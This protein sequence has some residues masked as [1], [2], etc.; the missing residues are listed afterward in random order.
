MTKRKAGTEY[1]A[2]WYDW[3]S[4]Q[5]CF[6]YWKNGERMQH[7][8][9]TK[10]YFFLR[11]EDAEIVACR[12]FDGLCDEV[13]EAGPYIKLFL[14]YYD[15]RR[16]VFI[17]WLRSKGV[18]PLEADVHPV[19]RYMF[20][21][22]IKISTNPKILY[23][24]I[25]TDARK[26]GWEDVGRHRLL[27]IAYAGRGEKVRCLIVDDSDD[28]GEKDLLNRFF[29]VIEKYDTLVAWNGAAYDEVVLRARAKHYK[30]YPRWNTINFLDL[31]QLFKKY[32]G[33]D[34]SGSGVRISFS[35]ENI[36]KT[37]LGK[38]KVK[39]IAVHRLIDVFNFE[40]D[41]LI[42]YNKRDVEI[43]QELDEKLGYTEAQTALAH[44]CN[45]FLC[46]RSLKSGY[47]VDG[48]VL[49]HAAKSQTA[50]FRTKNYNEGQEEER[51]IEGAFVMDPIIGLHEQVCDL[52]FSS[53]YPSIMIAWNVSPEKK[54]V[55]E[56]DQLEDYAIAANKAKFSNMTSGSFPTIVKTA[57]DARSHWKK[58][59]A[60]LEKEGQE[61]SVEH[62]IAKNRSDAW[63]VLA[64]SMYGMLSS[65][66][67]RYYDP[68]CGEAITI[69]GKTIIQKVIKLAGDYGIKVVYG[70]TD[71]VFIKS[72]K[73]QAIEFAGLAEKYL[74]E[75]VK[76]CG[77]LPGLIKLKLDAEFLRIFFTAKKRYAGKKATGKW[78]VRGLELV[79]SDGCK[80]AREFQRKMVEYVLEAAHPNAEGA[81][82]IV[83]KWADELDEG[84]VDAEFL[85]LA[86]SLSRSIE[87][88]KVETLHVRIAKEL[89]AKGK[90]V[91]VGM[92]IPY[93]VVGKEGARL[94][95]VH[96]DDYDG[97]YDANQYWTG[98]VFP[99]VQRILEAVLPSPNFE[100]KSFLKYLNRNKK[101]ANLF[102]RKKNDG[103][104]DPKESGE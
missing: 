97:K 49:K 61:N 72:S 12:K 21:S 34:E 7:S 81:K 64:N 2:G 70:D 51:G 104:A 99:P 4:R 96:I 69:T 59:A 3:E 1:T 41:K 54:I 17:E 16:E 67:A 39:D 94:K 62:R 36:A 29:N 53:L 44:L 89:M 50:H 98:K 40:P 15:E 73:D 68:D 78:D 13:E 48:F 23:Y 30:L 10:W 82:E 88:Y 26:G 66:F 27:S 93:I 19:D 25:E 86:Q 100:W 80:Y 63:K 31:M 76:E 28:K 103:K 24:D 5:V 35:L 42:E 91:Y 33:R 11:R 6:S 58:E 55:G 9:N 60:R 43:M 75:W 74:D 32:Y 101:Q 79:R 46:D 37:V 38:G 71:S 84:K 95:A 92:K 90:E 83:M 85:L 56:A 8:F 47:L 52:D 65:P 57:L 77:A 102:G 18:E 20:D 14:P 87:S 45:R 22:E